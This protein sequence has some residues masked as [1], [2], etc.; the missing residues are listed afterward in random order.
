MLISTEELLEQATID[1]SFPPEEWPHVLGEVLDE[2]ELIVRNKFPAPELLPRP[3]V[4]PSQGPREE[5]TVSSSQLTTSIDS[6]AT[7]KENA[8]PPARPPIPTFSAGQSRAPDTDYRPEPPHSAELTRLLASITDTLRDNFPTH[9]PHT[10]QRLAELVLRPKQHYRFLPPYLRALDRVINVS[11]NT[12]AFPIPGA[13]LPSTI[14]LNG[15]LGASF[16]ATP[17]LGSDESL[18][19]ALLTPI[20]WLS[21]SPASSSDRDLRSDSVDAGELNGINGEGRIE[22]VSV[23]NGVMAPVDTAM[24]TELALRAEG[25]VTQGELIRQ[26]QEAG[27]VRRVD[28]EMGGLE[29]EEPHARGPPEIDAVDT[30]PQ[31]PPHALDLDAAVGRSRREGSVDRELAP[32]VAGQ[33]EVGMGGMDGAG[34]EEK[35]DDKKDEEDKKHA[36][37]KQEVR[38]ETK[39]AEDAEEVEV[40]EEA[41]KDDAIK[42]E[43]ATDGK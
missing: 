25:A 35:G 10:V 17:A 39:A 21:R 18:G 5:V 30:G 20:P 23:V 37:E 41:S 15:F 9:P 28:D 32:V 7:N 13:S 31:R 11:S 3:P 33:G 14:T 16:D 12:A 1:G 42:D 6:Q 24:T 34:S 29:E 2:I 27:V 43:N 38:Q 26:E 4:V 36:E 22:T 8:P 19:G 40:K